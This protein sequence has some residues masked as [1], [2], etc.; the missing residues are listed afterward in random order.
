MNKPRYLGL[1][2]LKISKT[3]MH[4][5]WY[6]SVKPKYRIMLHGYR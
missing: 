2:I 1:S 5:F 6:D 3:L 4:G